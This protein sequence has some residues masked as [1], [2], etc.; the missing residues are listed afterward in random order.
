MSFHVVVIGW[1]PA[2][3]LKDAASNPLIDSRLLSTLGC[4]DCRSG[5]RA[6]ETTA[7][8]LQ[9]VQTNS[10]EIHVLTFADESMAGDWVRHYSADLSGKQIIG[11]TPTTPPTSP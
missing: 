4:T 9:F 6:E 2:K 1:D 3:L 11:F 5:L 7:G 8:R 10:A